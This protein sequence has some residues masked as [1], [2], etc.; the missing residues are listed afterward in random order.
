VVSGRV[1]QIDYTDT[2]VNIT[3]EAFVSTT[4]VSS[5]ANP[6]TIG[7]EVT[8][9]ATIGTPASGAPNR[10]G[11]VTFFVDSKQLGNP[12]DVSNNQAQIKTSTLPGGTHTITA[13]YSG[14]SNFQGSS[15]TLSQV[16]KKIDS[17]TTLSVVSDTNPVDYGATYTFRA[18]VTSKSG[19]GPTPSGDV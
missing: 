6:A 16:V 9:T 15:G 3:M 18:T 17:S 7:Q 5:N 14:D 8:F 4:S 1:F 12:V 13:T 2:D 19:S 11:T 10:T